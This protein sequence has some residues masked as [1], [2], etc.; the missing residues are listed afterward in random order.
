[1][2]AA[3]CVLALAVFCGVAEAGWPAKGRCIEPWPS[4]TACIQVSPDDAVAIQRAI[5][6]AAAIRAK[7]RADYAA[8]NKLAQPIKDSS[9]GAFLLSGGTYAD[10]KGDI[11]EAVAVESQDSGTEV[12]FKVILKRDKGQWRVLYFDHYR[13]KMRRAL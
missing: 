3:Y 2:R 10:E 5:I 6:K 12:G 13:K 7:S 11:L 1:M 8:V 9:I 4:Q